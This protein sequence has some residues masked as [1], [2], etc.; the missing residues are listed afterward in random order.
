MGGGYKTGR[1]S[2]PS[3]AGLSPHGRGI[4]L[5]SLVQD[6]EAGPIPAWAGDTVLAEI[7]GIPYRAY[8]RMGGGYRA[9]IPE[10][11]QIWGLS[12]HGRGILG[13]CST[14]IAPSGPIPAWAGDTTVLPVRAESRGAYPRMGGGYC[15]GWSRRRADWGLS[16][17]GRGIQ[18][19]RRKGPRRKGAYPRMGGGYWEPPPP[20]WPKAGLSPHGRGIP[21]S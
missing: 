11:A 20:L 9:G 13:C 15:A 8:P 3:C 2:R 7:T 12:P 21:F 14:P 4:L 10:S 6:D 16:P 1:K 5:A 19:S 17:H 18:G